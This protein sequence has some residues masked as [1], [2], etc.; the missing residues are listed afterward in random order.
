MERRQI[1]W[2]LFHQI[3][4]IFRPNEEAETNSKYPIS[5]KKL[6]KGDWA[7]STRK[8]VLRWDL[9]TIAHLLRLQTRRK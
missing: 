6:G 2:H 9:D 1:I 4:Q 3:N 7:R 5:Q 8:T